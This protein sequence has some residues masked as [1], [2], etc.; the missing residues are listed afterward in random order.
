[1]KIK[2]QARHVALTKDLKDYVKRRISYALGSRDDKIERIVVTLSD[3]NGPKGG[4]D[5]R[6]KVLIKLDGK[7]DIVID[8]KQEHFHSAIDL[9]VDRASRAVSRRIER[10]QNKARKLKHSFRSKSS[11]ERETDRL[12]EDYE[13]EYGY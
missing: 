10:L 7:N 1:M 5:K 8:D 11:E 9:A 6:C 2:I 4:E 3:V 13:N 12:Y